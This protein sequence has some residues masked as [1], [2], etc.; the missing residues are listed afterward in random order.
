M[1]ALVESNSLGDSNTDDWRFL[2][3]VFSILSSFFFL[4]FFSLFFFFSYRVTCPTVL[5]ILMSCNFFVVCTSWGLVHNFLGI[6]IL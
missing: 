3:H 5:L 2:F 6:C 1:D 4:F